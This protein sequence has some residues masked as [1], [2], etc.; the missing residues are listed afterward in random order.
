MP[1]TEERVRILIADNLEVD[2]HSV[3]D[4]VDFSQSLS[5]IGVSSMDI[6][7]FAR[8]VQKEFNVQF[9][10]GNCAE[11]SSLSE[12]VGFLDTQTA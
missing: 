7:A 1:S 4:S 11:L 9:S 12:L 6:V 3:G 2:G 5:D 8:V 10:P